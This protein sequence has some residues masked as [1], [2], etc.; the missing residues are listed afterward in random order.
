MK[1]VVGLLAYLAAG[2]AFVASI[3]RTRLKWDEPPTRARRT[4]AVLS[5]PVIVALVVAG[6]WDFPPHEGPPGEEGM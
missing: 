2:G 1:P 5:W 6:T 3:G 4:I